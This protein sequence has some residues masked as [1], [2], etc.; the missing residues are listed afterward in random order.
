MSPYSPNTE[1]IRKA[2][3]EIRSLKN[4]LYKDVA[5]S[6]I[7]ERRI[8]EFKTLGSTGRTKFDFRPFIDMELETGV[9]GELCFCILTA[10]SSAEL[11]IRIQKEIGEQGFMNLSE[12]E[13]TE[14]LSKMGHRFPG[15]R[16]KYIVLARSFDL[17][18]VMKQKSGKEARKILLEVKGL[19]LKESS[20]FLRNIGYPDVAIADR[21]IYRFL[22][23][24]KLVPY[25]KSISHHIYMECERILEKISEESRIPLP[26][27]DLY[28]FFKQTGV[29]LK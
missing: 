28:I 23:R 13:L 12:E 16:A 14:R 3:E 4:Q 1:L 26:S 7:I 19:G 6:E 15:A 22:V 29:V 24:H 25:K 8:A 10:N 21:H 9:F 17:S 18:K 27:L 5:L 11:G 20:H 2:A